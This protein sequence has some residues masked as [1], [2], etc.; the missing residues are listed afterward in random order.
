M[1]EGFDA[2]SGR[3]GGHDPFAWKRTQTW[4]DPR[5][6]ARPARTVWHQR[7]KC[8]AENIDEMNLPER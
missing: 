3:G 1:A 7:R 6:R 2:Y 5:Y 4:L 8:G